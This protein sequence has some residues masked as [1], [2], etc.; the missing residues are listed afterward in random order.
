[1]YTSTAQSNNSSAGSSPK[2]RDRGAHR[3]MLAAASSGNSSHNNSSS[4]LDINNT[5]TN[6]TNSSSINNNSSNNI[7]SST[8]SGTHD[9][10]TRERTMNASGSTRYNSD[11]DSSGG[12]RRQVNKQKQQLQL[13][14]HDFLIHLFNIVYCI[15]HVQMRAHYGMCVIRAQA[16]GN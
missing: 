5:G 1:M 13:L 4:N 8:R 9:R 6:G 10:P 11:R 12:R 2:S 14:E 15:L 7:S 16:L 3:D